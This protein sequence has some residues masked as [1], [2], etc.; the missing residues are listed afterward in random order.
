MFALNV[1]NFSSPDFEEKKK[2]EIFSLKF[3]IYNKVNISLSIY[4]LIFLFSFQF[5]TK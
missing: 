5:L 4:Y 3:A 2:L 1:G